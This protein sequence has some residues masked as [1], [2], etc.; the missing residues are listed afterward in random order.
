MVDPEQKNAIQTLAF[1]LLYVLFFLILLPPLMRFMDEPWG[2]ALYGGLVVGA[3][4]LAF[5]LR[6]LGRR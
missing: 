1:A 2:K 4:G 6:S 3:V 5:R